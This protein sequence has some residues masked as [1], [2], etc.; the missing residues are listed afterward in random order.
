MKSKFFIMVAVISII[1]LIFST[2]LPYAFAKRLDLNT[3]LTDQH[4][5]RSSPRTYVI[6]LIGGLEY[7]I[8]V[9]VLDFWYMDIKIKISTNPYIVAGQMVDSNSYTGEIV[10]FMPSRSGN[11][12]ILIIG[13][14][15][16]SGF[17]DI[18]V[19]LGTTSPATAPLTPFYGGIYLLVLILPSSIISLV[20]MFI[21][22]LIRKKQK[23]QI[24]QKEVYTKIHYQEKEVDADALVRQNEVKFCPICGNKIQRFAQFCANC[25]NSIT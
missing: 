25:G 23:D 24:I 16:S 20:G 15:Y 12:Y 21:L 22:L 18:R 6:T 1:P 19:D 13:D 17:F 9:D 8:N 5:S 10:N 11:Y 3:P 7:T 14:S 2:T 4:T